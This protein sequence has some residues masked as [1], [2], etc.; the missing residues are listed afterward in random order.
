M[1]VTPDIPDRYAAMGLFTEHTLMISNVFWSPTTTYQ[2]D[3]GK[4]VACAVLSTAEL[5]NRIQNGQR[6]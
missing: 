2:L 4:L 1:R 6:A 3:V 5:V